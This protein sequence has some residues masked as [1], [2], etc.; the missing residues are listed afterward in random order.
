MLLFMENND[1]VN[2]IQELIKKSNIK[3]LSFLEEKAENK[4]IL[5]VLLKDNVVKITTDFNKYCFIDSIISEIKKINLSFLN[6]QLKTLDYIFSILIKFCNNQLNIQVNKEETINDSYHIHQK[7][8]IVSK[9]MLDFEELDKSSKILRETNNKYDLSIFPKDL[10]FNPN[11]IFNILKNE[12]KHINENMKYK[13]FVTPI[14]NN[15]YELSLKLKLKNPIIEKIKEKLNYDYIEIKINIEPKMYPFVSPKLEFI[16]PSIKLPLVYNLMNLN[17]LKNENWISTTSLEWIITKLGESL[18]PIIQDYVI[19]EE[20]KNKELEALLIKLAVLIKENNNTEDI[21]KIDLPKINKDTDIISASKYWNAGTGYGHA[22]LKAINIAD[23]L[24]KQNSI[25]LSLSKLLSDINKYIKEDKINNKEKEDKINNKEKEDILD[26]IFESVLPSFIFKYIKGL[27]LIEFDKN[28]ELYNEIFNILNKFITFNKTEQ[29]QDFIN[30]ISNA[31]INI[32]DELTFIFSL[33]DYQQND[34]Y[35]LIHCL[36]DSYKSNKKEIIIIQEKD[37]FNNQEKEYEE[38]MK[39]K[40]FGTFNI[41]EYHRFLNEK[42]GN[43]SKTSLKPIQKEIANFRNNLPL[44]WGS[45]IFVRI[46]EKSLKLFNFWITGPKN[47]PYENG[48]FEY[49]VS[50]PT[51]YPKNYPEVLL[52]TTGNSK[53]RFNPNLYKCGKVCLSLIGTWAAEESES[54]NEKTSTMLQVLTSI[55]SGI[56]GMDEPYYNEPSYEKER[57]T[58]QGIKNNN[59]YNEPLYVGTVKFAIN[60]MIKNPPPTM[61][62]VIKMHF[63]LKKDEIIKTTLEWQNKLNEGVIDILSTAFNKLIKNNP[64]KIHDLLN[65]SLKNMTDLINTNTKISIDSLTDIIEEVF[66][67]NNESLDKMINEDLKKNK[68]INKIINHDLNENISPINHNPGATF[69]H[70]N[71]MID[72]RIEMIALLETL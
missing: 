35:L 29:L 70:R 71:E 1:Y 43:I 2:K 45:S 9:I 25:T 4:F 27:T 56:M 36:A 23:L 50:Y 16:K 40:Q 20:T 37:C 26:I 57:G 6:L 10:L 34:K 24:E 31:F 42:S 17:I 63:K 30:N 68:S 44:H 19:L 15:I 62:E 8:N 33:K 48:F 22:G 5:E 60:D 11:Q 51:E 18:E 7:I 53:I 67:N 72:A 61:E 66:K 14:N 28:E 21:I 41:P 12:I 55:Q 58:I 65:T 13:H 59:K 32:A 3:L 47:T 52:H 38:F 69:N 54:W 39:K 49:H 46:S 64:S